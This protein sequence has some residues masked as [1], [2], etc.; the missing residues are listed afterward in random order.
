MQIHKKQEWIG[1]RESC[2]EFLEG[3]RCC[4]KTVKYRNRHGHR[5]GHT[6]DGESYSNLMIIERGRE[7]CVMTSGILN[8]EY[9]GDK[10]P[11]VNVA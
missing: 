9:D 2:K 3:C 11:N 7:T 5:R 10:D 4:I 8:S 1:L 6:N